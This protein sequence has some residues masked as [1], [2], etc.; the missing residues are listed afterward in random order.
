MENGVIKFIGDPEKRIRE[1]YLRILR[2]IRFFLNYSRKK[3]DN[4][5]I[6]IIKQNLVGLSKIS[7]ERLLDELK[8]LVLSKGF[9]KLFKDD[10][11]LEIIG[12]IFPQLKNLS[13]FK[14]LNKYALENIFSQDFIFLISLMII[15][16]TDNAEYFLYKFNISN[17]EKKR[18]KF[19][20]DIFSKTPDKRIFEEKN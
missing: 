18:I 11:C 8:K 7:S 15:D 14:N 13:L 3:H 12:L 19:L 4:K 6:K 10:F 16:E 1:D 2:Y 9:L 5:I 17:E 20:K